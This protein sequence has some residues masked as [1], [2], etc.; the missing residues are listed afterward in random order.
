MNEKLSQALDHVGDHHIAQ[1]A[2]GKKKRRR[3]FRTL[4][5]AA[6]AVALVVGLTSM[7]KPIH[8]QT[9]SQASGSRL[10]ERP[11]RRD[12]DNY[13]EYAAVFDPWQE[14]AQGL[15]A[16]AVQAGEA[17]LPFLQASSVEMLG[18]AQGENR[19]WSP[20][21]AYIALAMLAETT[22]GESRA[23]IL[24]LLGTADLEALRDMVH[25]LWETTYTDNGK[26]VSVLANSL[27]L[28]EGLG[29]D[30]QVM[31]DLAWYH[32]A[33][34]YQG[35]LSSRRT[36]RDMNAWLSNATHGFLDDTLQTEPMSEETVLTLLS[37]VY[38]Q[39]KWDD[40]FSRSRNSEDIFHSPKG[41]VK[42]TFMNA[43][44]RQMYYYWGDSYGA[45]RLPLEN[46]SQMW[47]ILPDED[48]TVDDVLQ[49]GQYLEMIA[50]S[51]GQGYENSKYMKVNLSVPKF[52]IQTQKD[53]REHLVALGIT[54][55]FG[56]E[57]DLSPALESELPVWVSA[58]EQSTRVAIDEDGV[59]AASY[60]VIPGAGAAEPPEEIIDF[61]LDRPFLF[62]VAGQDGQNLFSGVVNQP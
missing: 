56:P 16:T 37:A 19:V 58:V 59:T 22:G 57:A 15:E 53:L 50:T 27:W 40:K 42:C 36:A 49:E 14:Q 10:G 41:D 7:P 62:V 55:V 6:L 48:K 4:V 33:S 52:D 38:F 30:Q 34:V 12:Y 23:Q 35:E 13:E 44:E 17:M 2:Q 45:V 11:N 1:A 18:D 46:G 28:D 9:I 5:A 39:S 54:D 31:D 60:I 21:N 26:E 61:V 32:H 43:K 29:F 51:H 24:E 3:L 20:I 8:A 47:L 25:A